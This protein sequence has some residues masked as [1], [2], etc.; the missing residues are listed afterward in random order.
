MKQTFALITLFWLL[1]CNS[2]YAQVPTTAPNFTVTDIDGN[3]HT[4]YDY[5]D[6]GKTV[7][8][9]F[10]TTWCE[11]CWWYHE[12]GALKDAYN[13]YGPNGTDEIM[14]FSIEVDD[15]T[16]FAQLQGIG[17]GTLGD[18]T[19]GTPY[20]MVDDQE[21]LALTYGVTG[22]PTIYAICPNRQIEDL[23]QPNTSEVYTY[24][25]NCPANPTTIDAAIVA[26]TGSA[27]TCNNQNLALSVSIQNAGGVT[28]T[29]A[30]ITASV[31]GSVI[32]S[33]NWVGSLNADATT[34][35]SLGTVMLEGT[36][37]VVF[38]I[39]VPNDA[40]A[41]NNNFSQ[42]LG[43][44]TAR[45]NEVTL[46]LLTD[47]YGAETYWEIRGE[48]STVYA[49]GGNEGVGTTNIGTGGTTAPTSANSL[50]NEQL[51]TET[52]T[53]NNSGC[54]EFF[55]GDFYGDG[56]CC[57]YGNGSYELKDIDG[58]ILL[59]GGAFTASDI[60]SFNIEAGNEAELVVLDAWLGGAYNTFTSS[61]N[62]NLYNDNLLPQSQ[63]Y[64]AAPW[65]YN[66]TETL[67]NNIPTNTV[68]WILVEI[69]DANNSN[70]IIESHA[71]LIL[72]DGSIVD[73]DGVTNGVKL[74]N[75]IAN[76]AYYI[77]LR[78]RN[79]IDVMSET[80]VQLPN[81]NSFSFKNA[82]NI[83]GTTNQVTNLGGGAYG[84]I[85]G[86]AN[87]DGVLTYKDFNVLYETSANN[88]Y[89]NGDCTFDGTVTTNDFS[90]LQNNMSQIA[91]DEVRY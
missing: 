67:P 41:G 14:V 57:D 23:A 65:N 66:G 20:P 15:F 25:Q 62:T 47:Q 7:V 89:L 16:T 49:S 55:I 2:I 24:F 46:E 90:F 59:S 76:T 82:N 60:K 83:N 52:I 58:N 6:E 56:I 17:G 30:T 74:E 31:N 36:E 73:A 70:T 35:V 63:P 54:Y 88:A 38:A 32:A 91:I 85:A 78:H 43:V 69:R 19:A 37:E 50:P 45:S 28:L 1:L 86:D 75:I 68:D 4:L 48:N 81:T 34:E 84:L 40:A 87:G 10:F 22:F 39:S 18:W 8:I 44:A 80:T 42:V 64:S 77:T 27:A 3:S 29:Q 11:P 5:L 13:M 79:H 12:D 53:L 61:M 33:T 21:A 9:D 72:S 51:Y 71:A 26:Y